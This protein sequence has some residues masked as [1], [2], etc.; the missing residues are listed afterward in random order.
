[1]FIINSFRLYIFLIL[2]IKSFRKNK[3]FSQ[4]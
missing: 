2:E 3:I 1:M 4:F